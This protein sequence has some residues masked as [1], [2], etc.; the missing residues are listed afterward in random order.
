MTAVTTDLT[1]DIT[2]RCEVLLAANDPNA[3]SATE[4]LGAQF[5]AG[6]A[7]VHFPEGQGGLG[8]APKI[9][10]VV[11]SVLGF[12]FILQKSRRWLANCSP[13]SGSISRQIF[14]SLLA[15][16]TVFRQCLLHC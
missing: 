3:V 5:D 7:W 2:A 13:T 10:T 16:G 1:Q 11:N 4:F 12:R 8:M 15:A 6:L 14:R 9:Q